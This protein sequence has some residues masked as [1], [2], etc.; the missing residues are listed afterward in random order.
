MS[1]RASVQE[2]ISALAAVIVADILGN[3]AALGDYY[4]IGLFSTITIGLIPA[5]VFA[6]LKKEKLLD[7]YKHAVS[8]FSVWLSI[9][10]AGNIFVSAWTVF[11]ISITT[12]PIV[13]GPVAIV[14]FFLLVLFANRL[15]N[16]LKPSLGVGNPPKSKNVLNQGR[17]EAAVPLKQSRTSRAFPAK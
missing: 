11:K 7:H 4:A 12:G 8:R 13:A 15:M 16:L 5:G 9:I 3:T 17:L 6:V 1:W 2:T 14:G 10:L